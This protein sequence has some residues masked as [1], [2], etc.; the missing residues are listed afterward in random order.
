MGF[1]AFCQFDPF[2]D[3]G[4]DVAGAVFAAFGV[5]AEGLLQGKAFFKYI[6]REFEKFEELLVEG[7]D[8]SGRR[9][10]W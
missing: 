7:Q 4:L 9:R 5:K 6:R 3:L 8:L 10:S 2:P 1:E